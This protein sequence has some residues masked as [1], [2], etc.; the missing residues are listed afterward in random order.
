MTPLTRSSTSTRSVDRCSTMAGTRTR[1]APV[2][3]ADMAPALAA[4]IRKSSSSYTL[5]MNSAASSRGRRERP[6][7]VRR[8]IRPASC[9][10]AALSRAIVS[11]RPGRCT[12]TTTSVPSGSWAP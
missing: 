1:S 6:S 7:A 12:F 5:S 2:R 11:S 3:V 9:M 4:S 10:I 8:S